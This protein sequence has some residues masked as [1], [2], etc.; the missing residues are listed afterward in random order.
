MK[1]IISVVGFLMDVVV[2]LRNE[3]LGAFVDF[4]P[5]TQR[6]RPCEKANGQGSIGQIQNISITTSHWH[7]R[8]GD[9]HKEMPKVDTKLLRDT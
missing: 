6:R 4:V 9:I 3:S 7:N 5:W 8:F 1:I 2:W